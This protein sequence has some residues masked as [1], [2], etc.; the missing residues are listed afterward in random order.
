MGVREVGVGGANKAKKAG[1]PEKDRQT[2]SLLNRG[3][4]TFSHIFA[5]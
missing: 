2:S 3:I 4:K 5:R 1:D